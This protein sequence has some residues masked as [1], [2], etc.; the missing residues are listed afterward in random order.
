[1]ELQECIT[2]EM[3]HVGSS[4]CVIFCTL[5]NS[6]LTFGHDPSL[7]LK[8]ALWHVG[9]IIMCCHTAQQ[10]TACWKSRGCEVGIICG[11]LWQDKFSFILAGYLTA[12]PTFPAPC[13]SLADQL[14]LHICPVRGP[15][16]RT[17]VKTSIAC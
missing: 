2:R 12:A 14:Y 10:G 16:V 8:D 15:T 9:S 17:R 5:Y 3:S 4:F 6:Q 7:A 13:S 11:D 1:M